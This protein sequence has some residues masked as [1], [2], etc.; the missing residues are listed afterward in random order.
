MSGLDKN[1][2]NSPCPSL[3]SIYAFKNLLHKRFTY[4]RHLHALGD[5]ILPGK[6][7]DVRQI[8]GEV[9]DAAAGGCQ[10][11]L[12][13]EHAHQETLHDGGHGESQQE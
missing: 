8:E 3:S 6:A 1:S 5:A 9:D 10:V 13:E 11:G 4:G 12:V 2:L 7:E